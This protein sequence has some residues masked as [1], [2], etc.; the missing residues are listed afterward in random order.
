MK[1]PVKST[2]IRFLQSQNDKNSKEELEALI[3]EECVLCGDMMI[4]AVDQL[5]VDDPE[6]F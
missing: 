4:R 3:S 1:H 5:L 2:R 6:V